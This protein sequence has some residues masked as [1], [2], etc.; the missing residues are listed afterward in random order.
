MRMNRIDR[1]LLARAKC[2]LLVV[3]WTLAAFFSGAVYS[4]TAGAQIA[5]GANHTPNRVFVCRN[6]LAKLSKG[7]YMSS[8]TANRVALKLCK[9]L[10]DGTTEERYFYRAV[11]TQGGRR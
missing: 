6:K 9:K 4:A 7:P 2:V 3:A 11:T 1:R 8:V 10:R 5:S